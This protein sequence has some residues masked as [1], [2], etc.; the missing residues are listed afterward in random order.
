L[1]T[2]CLRGLSYK[3]YDHPS[4]SDDPNTIATYCHAP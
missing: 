3:F 1:S 4:C 2:P